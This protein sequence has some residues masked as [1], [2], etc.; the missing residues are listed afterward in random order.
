MLYLSTFLS[1]SCEVD[2]SYAVWQFCFGSFFFV[3][4]A[5]FGLHL[6]HSVS[7]AIARLFTE[8]MLRR[9][10]KEKLIKLERP[11]KSMNL[12]LVEFLAKYFPI[13]ILWLYGPAETEG[14][15][16]G[17]VGRRRQIP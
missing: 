16:V 17:C 15:D 10:E 3:T 13:S 12:H 6:L 8:M 7:R 2:F 14:V 5:V 11:Q 9:L 1:R 4:A